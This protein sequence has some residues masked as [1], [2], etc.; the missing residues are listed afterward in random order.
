[1]SYAPPSDVSQARFVALAWASVV[2]GV[3]GVVGSPVVFLDD[4]AA[5]AGFTLGVIGL[6]GSRKV[7]A[8]VGMVLSVAAVVI[9]VLAQ[10][11]AAV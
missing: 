2:F 1:M 5:V 7:L 4:L 6:F 10:I 9:T 3:V 11:T 8:G